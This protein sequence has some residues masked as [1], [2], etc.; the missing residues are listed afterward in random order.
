M[1]SVIHAFP[2]RQA[3]IRVALAGSKMARKAD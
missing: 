2:A 3:V 1:D